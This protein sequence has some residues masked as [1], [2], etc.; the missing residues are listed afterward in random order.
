MGYKPSANHP[1]R[2]YAD[3]K[4]EIKKEKKEK[5]IKP[6]KILIGEIAEG[7]EKIEITT[8]AYGKEGRFLLTELPQ[9]RQAAW[10]AG[11]LKRNYG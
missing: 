2:Q 10:L 6:V 3:R 8:Y 11:V 7:W 4:I 5:K 9:V 1:W